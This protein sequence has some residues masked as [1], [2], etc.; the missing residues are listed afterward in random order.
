M[1]AKNPVG[2]KIPSVFVGEETGRIII[3]NYEYE[4]NYFLILN[5][6]L[7]FNINTHLLLPFAI[8]VG[9]CFLIMV[10]FM[11]VKCARERRRLR[12][13]RLS[14]RALKRIPICKFSKGDAY[15]TCAICLDDYIEGEKL[16]ILPCSHGNYKKNY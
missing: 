9:L 11:I 16:R 6:D 4:E 13:H 12:R 10:A 5:S 7:P 2:I 1:S 15:E 8:V 3:Y 14:S